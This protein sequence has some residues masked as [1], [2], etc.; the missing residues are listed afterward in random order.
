[1]AEANMVGRRDLALVFPHNE[2]DQA[3]MDRLYPRILAPE[4]V[5][6]AD[7]QSQLRDP[8]LE[9]GIKVAHELVLAGQAQGL[10]RRLK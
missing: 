3:D 1:M 9:A 2:Y 5:D 10:R 4:A 6:A 7:P 8:I